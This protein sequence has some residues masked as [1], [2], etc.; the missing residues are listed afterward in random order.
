MFFDFGLILYDLRRVNKA[1]FFISTIHAMLIFRN[2]MFVIFIEFFL[3]CNG[4][5][6]IKLLRVHFCGVKQVS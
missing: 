4:S 1:S 2:F 3:F 5:N 6:F